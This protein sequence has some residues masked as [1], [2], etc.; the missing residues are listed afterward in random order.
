MQEIPAGYATTRVAVQRI[1][2]HVLG[3]RRFDVCGR[4]GL[5]ASP[6]GL[7]TPAFGDEAE[8][9]RV[10]GDV[11]IREV[12]GTARYT[13]IS[14]ASLRR[15]AD[16][17]GVD[18]S[19]EFRCGND[20]PALGD[21]DAEIEV[22]PGSIAVLAG[23]FDFGWAALDEIVARL[24]PEAE[25]T[26]VQLWPEHFDAGTTVTV[27]SGLQVNLGASPGDGYEAE[28][29]LYV[30][31]WDTE[32]LARSPFWNAPFGAVL[33]RSQLSRDPSP[34]SSASRFLDEGLERATEL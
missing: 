30:G 21:V 9:I 25:P 27:E 7:A 29:Y 4:F 22:D 33:T 32:H 10:A 18:L 2:T 31:P 3:H 23:W 34:E 8:T 26:V 6:G 19:A 1:A 17:A 28:P 16:V 24:V 20:T 15:L 13:K 12:G 11:L 5:R 14:G